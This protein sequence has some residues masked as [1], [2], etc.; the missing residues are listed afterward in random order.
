MP[1]HDHLQ[2]T[3]FAQRFRATTLRKAD[4]VLAAYS[5]LPASAGDEGDRAE[6]QRQG[7][8]KAMLMHMSLVLRLNPAPPPDSPPARAASSEIDAAA[9]DALLRAARQHAEGAPDALEQTDDAA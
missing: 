2:P 6:I 7:A 3:R 9:L 1:F 8:L 5:S 4:E